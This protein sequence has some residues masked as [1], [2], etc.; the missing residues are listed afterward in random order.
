MTNTHASP[1]ELRARAKGHL[2]QWRE[3]LP[4][5]PTEAREHLDKASNLSLLAAEADETAKRVTE[6]RMGE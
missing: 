6:A 1:D 2:Q 3:L 5:S 4:T